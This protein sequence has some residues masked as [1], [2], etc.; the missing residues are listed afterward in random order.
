[1]KRISPHLDFPL[2]PLLI[3]TIVLS[4]FTSALLRRADFNA[5]YMV[6]AGSNFCDPAAAPRNLMIIQNSPNSGGYD[7]QFYYRLALDPF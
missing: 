1:M 4:L 7:G 6:M 2:A 3:T 5:T